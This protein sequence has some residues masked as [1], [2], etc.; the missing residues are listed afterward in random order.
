MEY[1]DYYRN[2][3]DW[4]DATE[5]FKPDR[6]THQRF[7][8]LGYSDA[9]A[10]RLVESGYVMLEGHD[11]VF[12]RYYAGLLSS[13]DGRV[14]TTAERFMPDGN[15]QSAPVE[16]HVAGS[17]DDVRRIVE[18]SQERST[19][20]LLFRGQTRHFPLAR[21]IP[22]PSMSVGNLG[23]ISL[24]PSLW[25]R[26]LAARPGSFLEFQNLTKF[27]WSQI[28]YA[29]FDLKDIE[30]RHQALLDAGEWVYTIAEMEDC[31]DPVV[32]AFGN[33]RGDLLLEFDQHAPALATLLQ[34]YGLLSPVLDLTSELDVALFF[35]THALEGAG[36]RSSYRF[37]GTNNRQAV[38]YLL[39]EDEREMLVH[40]RRRLFDALDPQRPAKQHCVIAT[41]AS[42]AINLPADFVRAVIRLDFDLSE[43]V[44]PGTHNLFPSPKEDRFL[45]ALLT[46]D[47]PHVT[48]FGGDQH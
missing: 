7:E 24:V 28:L 15:G 38:L 19:H 31:S 10:Q 16:V 43:I 25:R 33:V 3:F 20:R 14:R 44:G 2:E 13:T 32:A 1:W 23:E 36:L 6:A 34:H 26:L 41:S 39:K 37:V 46:H 40:E 4:D 29:G 21:P 48:S 27:E 47:T 45:R 17:I 35:A 8:A 42:W 22:N 12:D 9:E 11:I 30:R 5:R 18:M